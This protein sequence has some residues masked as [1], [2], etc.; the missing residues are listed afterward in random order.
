MGLPQEQKVEQIIRQIAEEQGISRDAARTQLHKFVCQG[1]CHWYKTK[2][3]QAGFDRSSLP[4]EQR[5]RIERMVTQVMKELPQGEV[6]AEIHRV[7][8]P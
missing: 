5:R 3:K 6:R 2:S 7:L 1:G 8:C 4:E